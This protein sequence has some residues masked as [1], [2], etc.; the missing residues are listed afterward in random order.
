VTIGVISIIP[1]N[2][3]DP[4]FFGQTTFGAGGVSIGDIPL[5]LLVAGLK[6][7]AGTLTADTQV[8]GPVLSEDDID[9]QAG[10]GSELAR[11]GRAAFRIPGVQLYLATP[12]NGGSPAAAT[13]TITI[14]GTWSTTGMWKYYIAGEVITGGIAATDSTSDVAADI[15]TAVTA[16]TNLPVTAAAVGP[17]VTL[18][19][20]NLSVRATDNIIFQDRTDIPSG[21][22]SVLAGGSAVTG[23]AITGSG[24]RM[25]GGAGTEDV[26][27]LLA[28]IK[29]T[30]F[31]RIAAA[32]RDSTN[33]GLWETQI[34]TMADPFNNKTQH[35]VFALNGSLSAANALALSPLNQW[36]AQLMWMLDSETP[37]PEIAAVMAA[38][39]TATEQT[40]PNVSYDDVALPG[41]VPQRDRNK[42]PSRANRVSALDNGVTPITSN[43]SGEALVVRSIT[44]RSQTSS[45]DPDARTLDTSESVVPDYVRDVLSI[46]WRTV[47]KV[48][49]PNVRDDPAPEERPLPAGVASPKLWNAAIKSQLLTLEDSNIVTEV[50]LNPPK[51][52]FNRTAKRLASIVPVVVL[53]LQHQI[54]VS[55]RQVPLSA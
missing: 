41:V 28:T 35:I 18:T 27:T 40:T 11:M 33:L 50:A 24:V 20:K 36:R 10:A 4:G 44:T 49:N 8:Y 3:K 13:A 23:D 37:P 25:T 2:D 7:S 29:E 43:E 15:V 42:W 32:Q 1:D 48:Q 45:G 31:N 39:R 52:V 38:L 14:G 46:Y 54:E 53:P 55:V 47:F 30:R 5:K 16:K 51:T 12:S 34:N 19:T 6:S 9:T 22:T 26:T 17:I 21:L